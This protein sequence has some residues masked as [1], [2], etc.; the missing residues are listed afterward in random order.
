M[1]RGPQRFR[2]GDL[3]RALR[4]ATKA[5]V[6]VARVEIEDGRIVLITAGADDKP[7]AAE[8]EKEQNPWHE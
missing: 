6:A 3:E 8:G 7:S 4:G 2:Q 1:S 5:G